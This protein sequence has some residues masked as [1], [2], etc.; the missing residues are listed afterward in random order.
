VPS[1]RDAQP[2]TDSLPRILH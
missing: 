1:N 2:S